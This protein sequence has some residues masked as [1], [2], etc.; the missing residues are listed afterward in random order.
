MTDHQDP[1]TAPLPTPGAGPRML[2]VAVHSIAPSLTNPRKHFDPAKL[3][4][5]A[6]SIKA[7]GV[8][9]PVLLRPL[10]PERLEDTFRTARAQGLPAPE[11]ELVAGERRWRA[12]QLAGVVEIP[13]MVRPMTDAHMLEAQL[14]ENLLREDVTELEEAEGYQILMDTVGINADEVGQRIGKSRSYVYG[15]LK[16]LDLCSQARQALREKRLDFSCA[17]EIARIPNAQLQIKALDW[18]TKADYNGVRPSARLV[19]QH[20]RNNYTLRLEYAPFDRDDAALCP[21]AGACSAC[22][23]RTGNHQDTENNGADVCMNPP[24]YHAKEEA[25]AA[26]LRERAQAMGAE[27]ITGR[28]AKALIP[29]PIGGS[30]DGYVRLDVASDSPIKGKPLRTVLGDVLEQSGIK[31][32]LI[33]NPYNTKELVAVVRHDQAA[34]LLKMAG[35]TEEETQLR[36]DA[37]RDAQ[38]KARYAEEDAKEQYEQQWRWATL[39]TI[40][41][42]IQAAGIHAEAIWEDAEKAV[43]AHVL[44]MVNKA[45]AT[46]LAELLQLGKVAPHDGLQ[47]YARKHPFPN[48]VALLALLLRDAQYTPMIWKYRPDAEQNPLLHAIAKRADV[49]IEQIKASVQAQIRGQMATPPPNT[50]AQKPDLP[51]DP[52]APTDRGAG[53][54][55]AKA[56][57]GGK[58][59]RAPAARAGG[60]EEK[61]TA[62]AASAGIAAA[63]QALT[64]EPEPGAKAPSND[65]GAV[66]AGASQPQGPLVT[67]KRKKTITPPADTPAAGGT[68][69]SAGHG[70][71]NADASTDGAA[72][73]TAIG[74]GQL[75]LVGSKVRVL[76]SSH[77]KS[78][79]FIGGEGVVCN[80]KGTWAEVKLPNPNPKM[81]VPAFVRFEIDALEVL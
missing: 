78:A 52:A 35:K 69:E 28:E 77:Q 39:K 11:Y 80:I 71:S 10:P 58:N 25:H 30:I 40:A 47:D 15:R 60:G 24:C 6:D 81:S 75:P 2:H 27:I 12:C 37:T 45:E 34:E 20:V 18:A 7:S 49:D 5:L 42:Y 26:Q 70:Q 57:A 41:D 67:L 31:P 21:T 72:K 33:E 56:G 1:Y 13:A 19:K 8:H 66:A 51:L 16:V 59:R 29:S 61:L 63:L 17:L 54:G 68:G 44:R 23:H 48:T 38:A 79:R 53:K 62:Q 36:E 50:A 3:Q 4:E 22:P 9:Q 74:T 14:I 73:S 64:G 76:R 32:T 43:A 55:K 46:K 65:A